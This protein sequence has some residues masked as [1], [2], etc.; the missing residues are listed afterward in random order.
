MQYLKLLL[1]GSLLRLVL[2]QFRLHDG[3]M[4][5]DIINDVISGRK[6]IDLITSAFDSFS[7]RSLIWFLC[8]LCCLT[9]SALMVAVLVFSA[10]KLCLSCLIFDN[11]HKLI[12][13][14][15]CML[16]ETLIWAT[17]PLLQACSLHL[18]GFLF[19]LLLMTH[20]SGL[21]SFHSELS[22]NHSRV[23]AEDHSE[24]LT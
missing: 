14:C 15:S 9:W 12:T 19:E 18:Q 10:S 8:I 20:L 23:I 7:L 11:K 16:V 5:S 1:L 22:S 3:I 2:F 13:R 4:N 24:L 6:Y 21:L 17:V